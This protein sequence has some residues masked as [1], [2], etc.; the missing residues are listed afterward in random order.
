MEKI[1]IQYLPEVEEY[2]NELAYLLFQKEYFGFIENSFEYI[3]EIVD[4]I[5]YNLPIFPFKKTPENLTKFG[6][7]YIFYKANHTTTWS[8]RSHLNIKD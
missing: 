6:L 5:D 2:L 8:R 1:V 4:F 3:D 7:K